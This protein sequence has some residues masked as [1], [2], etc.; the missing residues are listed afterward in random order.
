M[1]NATFLFSEY[2]YIILICKLTDRYSIIAILLFLDNAFDQTGFILST[3]LSN[4][5]FRESNNILWLSLNSRP[6]N[7]QNKKHKQ[8]EDAF[9]CKC[10]GEMMAVFSHL[11][12]LLAPLR[13]M[14]KAIP[15]RLLTKQQSCKNVMNI[16][17]YKIGVVFT[18]ILPIFVVIWTVPRC[19]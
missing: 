15:P 4:S 11:S 16:K 13:I 5:L 10:R 2:K 14:W 3:Y 17:Y 9:G 18:T 8:E 19:N 1:A 12:W 6:Q 7:Q